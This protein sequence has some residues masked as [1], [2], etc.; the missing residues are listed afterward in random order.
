MKLLKKLSN[1]KI[2]YAVILLVYTLI[3]I[4]AQFNHEFWRDEMQA[5]TIARDLSLFEI[6]EQMQYE[7]HPCLYHLI[8]FPFAKLG[9]PPIAMGFVSVFFMLLAGILIMYK[10]PFNFF[11]KILLLLSSPFMYFYSIMSRVYSIIPFFV[12]LLAIVHKKRMEKPLL[13]AAI[14][15]VIINTHAIMMCFAG[16]VSLFFLR[17]IIVNKKIKDKK[18]LASLGIIFLGVLIFFLQFRGSINNNS[19]IYDIDE[20]LTYIYSE[21][22]II[23][24]LY[25]CL[26]GFQ[27][28]L[29]SFIGVMVY[30]NVIL[31]II[32]FL[33]LVLVIFGLIKSFRNTLLVLIPVLFIFF[34]HTFVWFSNSQRATMLLFYFMYAVW[35]HYDCLKEASKKLKSFYI[36]QI[37]LSLFCLFTIPYG[38]KSLNRDINETISGAEDTARYIEENLN[39]AQFICPVDYVATA[40]TGYIDEEIF[41]SN[42]RQ[43]Y[44]SFVK[45]D[46]FWERDIDFYE[47]LKGMNTFVR[48]NEEQDIYILHS[49]GLFESYDY[50][51]YSLITMG[52]IDDV[53][54][55][56]IGDAEES[57]VIYKFTDRYYDELL[58]I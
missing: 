42:I 22:P 2:F 38:I 27:S 32:L 25:T 55:S 18:Y 49:W 28:N 34:F 45:W 16:V 26:Y 10:S 13:F 50:H 52:Y 9:F 12:C 57:F 31:Y 7:G 6:F 29:F 53:Y 8:L 30:E 23:N 58:S 5:W 46:Q 36:L 33:L 35:T 43:R 20:T 48:K 11:V 51:M 47:Y 4:Y 39:G 44:F 1:N 14:I 37:I 17:D 24:F 40:V 54:F 21:N 56:P 15:A 19:I 3:M 41:Y